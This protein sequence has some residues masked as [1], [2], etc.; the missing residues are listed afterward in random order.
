[1]TGLRCLQTRGN[2]FDA[3][4]LTDEQDVGVCAQGPTYSISKAR[5]VSADLVL[6]YHGAQPTMLIFDRIGHELR[7][8]LTSIR[9][10]LETLLDEDLDPTVARRFLEVARNEAMRLGR[11]VDGMFDISVLDLRSGPAHAEATEL[12]SA[13]ATAINALVS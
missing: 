3:A 6:R 12:S 11:L 4:E 8:P 5:N 10:Y 9:G 13:I 1:M 2:R 7:T